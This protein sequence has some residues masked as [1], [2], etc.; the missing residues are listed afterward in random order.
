MKSNKVET[1]VPQQILLEKVKPQK[2]RVATTASA[3]PPP[4][5]SLST[6]PL[7]SVSTPT[8][9]PVIA[10]GN[11]DL[12]DLGSHIRNS[13]SWKF[14]PAVLPDFEI[15]PRRFLTENRSQYSRISNDFLAPTTIET[16][17]DPDCRFETPYYKM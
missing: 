11:R 2:P 17:T 10:Y 16:C 8:P 12:L 1:N 6:P 9:E 14:Q 13:N 15:V 4:D 7:R 3:W 5:H